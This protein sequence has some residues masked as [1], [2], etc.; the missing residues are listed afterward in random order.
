MEYEVKALYAG[1]TTPQV[2][3]VSFQL[4]YPDW[5]TLKESDEWCRLEESVASSQTRLPR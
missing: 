3:Q 5:L 4:A 1:R 2:V